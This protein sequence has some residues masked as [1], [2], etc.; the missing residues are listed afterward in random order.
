MK[1]RKSPLSERVFFTKEISGIAA[2]KVLKGK[3]A[4]A[5]NFLGRSFAYSSTRSYGC[6][7]LSFGLF[8]A[9]LNLGEYYF[10]DEPE[11]AIPLTIGVVLAILSIPLLVF[12]K[13]MCIALQDFSLT[14]YLLF[15]F[16]SIK[17][18]HRNVTHVSVSPLLAIFLGFIPAIIGFFTS[19]QWVILA[20]IVIVVAVVAFNTPEFSMILTLLALPYIPLFSSPAEEIVLVSL[21]LV[22]LLSFVIKVAIGKRVYNLDIYDVLLALMMFFIFIG[23]IVGVGDDAFKNSLVKIVLLLGYFPAANLI[24]NRR[25][26]DCAINSVIISAVPITVIAIFEFFLG[27]PESLPT[28]DYAPFYE[29]SKNVSVFFSDSSILAAFLLVSSLLTLSFFI[30]KKNKYKKA[31]YLVVFV[32]ELFTLG[33]I[34]QPVAWLAIILVALAYFVI[35]SR[36]IPTDLLMLFF[37]L[38]HLLLLLP[39]KALD[40]FARFFGV[41]PLYSQRLISYKTALAVFLDNMF[42]GIGIG[43]ESYLESS[44]GQTPIFNNMLGMAVELGIVVFALFLIAVILRFRHI[45][46]YRSYVRTSHVRVA[47]DTTALVILALLIFGIDAYIFADT[48][49]FYLFWV[50]FGVCTSTLRTAKKEYDDRLS[51]YGDSRSAES[52][53]IDVQIQK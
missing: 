31:F 40:A 12:D 29:P 2:A 11:I 25:L 4:R 35:S 34:M 1:Q 17:R 38:P 46:Y 49:V 24:T 45:S 13:P 26:A 52:S 28:L 16:F 41:L 37:I 21:L 39:T 47:D 20:L 10:A 48:T 51:Y 27:V 6:F 42:L 32:I 43:T 14:D 5:L 22:T 9:F 50:M 7:L 33:L 53:V 30:Q 44:G 8:S 23:G 18:M 36:K 15:E 3:L 19:I